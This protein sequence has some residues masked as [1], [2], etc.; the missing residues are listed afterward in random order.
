MKALRS[1]EWI[2]TVTVKLG[3]EQKSQKQ[4]RCYC[5]ADGKEQKVPLAGQSAEG[6]RSPRGIRGRIAESKKADMEEYIQQAMGLVKQYIPPDPQRLQA[7]KDKGAQTMTVLDSATR[8]RAEFPS[9]L[10]PG[11]ALLVDVDPNG[12]RIT[13]VS[14]VTYLEND[15]KDV[16]TLDV[17]FGTFQDGTSYPAKIVLSGKSKDL[18]VLIENSGY[19]K[20][21]S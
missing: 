14:V 13:G 4:N 20:S 2:E 12:D 1:Y 18:D 9:Y 10:K 7:V 6:G 8:L 15:P 21:G 11:D 3:G 19:R 16:I 5:G 17:A